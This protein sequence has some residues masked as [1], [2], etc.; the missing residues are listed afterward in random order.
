MVRWTVANAPDPR[1]PLAAP[2]LRLA[3]FDFAAAAFE[4]PPF[5]V[6]ALVGFFLEDE[7][8]LTGLACLVP[9]DFFFAGPG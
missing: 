2:F 6:F 8:F 7:A 5:A 4:R 3:A 9:R 1:Q